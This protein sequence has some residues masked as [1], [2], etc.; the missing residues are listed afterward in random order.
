MK[1]IYSGVYIIF[2]Y[3]VILVVAQ[4]V[5]TN[6]GFVIAIGKYWLF[7]KRIGLER[8][9]NVLQKR[10]PFVFELRNLLRY[11]CCK[12]QRGK[13][14]LI[15]SCLQPAGS[16]PVSRKLTA[17]DSEWKQNQLARIFFVLFRASN[18]QSVSEDSY[19]SFAYEV[20]VFIQSI[21]VV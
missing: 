14:Q 21:P 7:V 8:T 4:I 2:L 20:S 15:S 12:Q 19:I 6:S 18:A 17:T 16:F 1:D 5:K 11:C 10:Q 13:I 3:N 9:G